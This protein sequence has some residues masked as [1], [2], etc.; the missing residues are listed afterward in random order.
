MQM[1]NMSTSQ[2]QLDLQKVKACCGK[3]VPVHFKENFAIISHCQVSHVKEE[4]I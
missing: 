4:P 3:R 1:C 2:L